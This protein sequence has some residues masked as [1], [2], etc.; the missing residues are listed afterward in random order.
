M[1]TLFTGLAKTHGVDVA[2]VRHYSRERDVA[3]DAAVI[4]GFAFISRW[5]RIVLQAASGND[6]RR[7]NP[8]SG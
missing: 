8:A 4:F 6:F 5:L 3:V 7:A 2:A 1:E